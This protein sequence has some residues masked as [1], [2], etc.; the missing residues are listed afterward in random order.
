MTRPQKYRD[1]VRFLR[2][3]GWEFKR[4]RGSHE[5]WGPADGGQTFPIVQHAGQVSPGVVRQLQSVFTDTPSEW[6]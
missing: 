6:N 2:S 4:Q 3:R 5:I 1:V